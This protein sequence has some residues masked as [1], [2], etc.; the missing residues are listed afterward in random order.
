MEVHN[1]YGPRQSLHD[2]VEPIGTLITSHHHLVRRVLAACR[3]CP[4]RACAR[5][6]GHWTRPAVARAEH[7]SPSRNRGLMGQR[8]VS[9]NRPVVA[10]RAI[11]RAVTGNRDPSRIQYVVD[12]YHR[13]HNAELP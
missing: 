3:P 1:G 13:R 9:D 5:L 12:P 10:A 7:E 2:F 4:T 8:K 6:G 11:S